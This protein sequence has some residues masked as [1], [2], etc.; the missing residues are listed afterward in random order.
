MAKKKKKSCTKTSNTTLKRDFDALVIALEA[1]SALSSHQVSLASALAQDHVEVEDCSDEDDHLEEEVDYSNL[2]GE[3]ISRSKFFKTPPHLLIGDAD[4]YV[5]NP[6][7]KLDL[8][9]K[10]MLNPPSLRTTRQIPE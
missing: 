9:F 7:L 2:D 1:P 8:L 10:Q 4:V 3:Q 6:T 5:R